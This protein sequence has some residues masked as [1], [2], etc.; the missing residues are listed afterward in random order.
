M[1]IKVSDLKFWSLDE[2][3]KNA[4]QNPFTNMGVQS[5]FSIG[6]IVTAY[7]EVDFTDNTIDFVIDGN[8]TISYEQ[9]LSDEGYEKVKEYIKNKRTQYITDLCK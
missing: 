7:I 4:E 6:D 3:K 8:T 9:D 2:F 5:I 1:T